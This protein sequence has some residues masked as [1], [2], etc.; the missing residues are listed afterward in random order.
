MGA[1]VEVMRRS[2]ALAATRRRVHGACVLHRVSAAC[3]RQTVL[4]AV[5]LTTPD[6][7]AQPEFD[8]RERPSVTVFFH[9]IIRRQAIGRG[10]SRMGSITIY[11]DADEA[12]AS[13]PIGE[14]VSRLRIPPGQDPDRVMRA[15]GWATC[16]RATKRGDLLVVPVQPS[17]WRLAPF[18]T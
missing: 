11:R 18:A 3:G 15:H 13:G 10:P 16:G 6:D 4:G 8:E 1:G 7:P 5:V 14:Q 12:A 9:A 17:D 2:R